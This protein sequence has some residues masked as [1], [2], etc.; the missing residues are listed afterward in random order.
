DE[1][2]Y[3]TLAGDL[4]KRSAEEDAAPFGELSLSSLLTETPEVFPAPLRVLRRVERRVRRLSAEGSA[5]AVDFRPARIAVL[6]YLDRERALS[7]EMENY[8]G[9][10]YEAPVLAA[11]LRKNPEDPLTSAQAERFILHSSDP[12]TLNAIPFEAAKDLGAGYAELLRAR[13]LYAEVEYAAAL[14]DYGVWLKAAADINAVCDFE[15]VSPVFAEIG[16]SARHIGEESAWAG[17]LFE[18]SAGLNGS[19][20]YA[21]AYQAGRL[22]R[23]LGDYDK[24]QSALLLAADAVKPGLD[25]DRAL[26]FGWRAM[27]EDA[28]TTTEEELIFL[29]RAVES[30]SNPDRFGDVM[31]EFLHRRIRR[32]EWTLLEQAWRDRGT[33]WPD[34]AR[35]LG[36]L[37]L[38]F[39]SSEGRLQNGADVA[40]L[41]K[42]AFESAPYSWSGLRA[43]GLLDTALPEAT[44]VDIGDE[45]DNPDGLPVNDAVLRLYLR[46]GLV[47]LAYEEV[48][49]S[50]YLYLEETVRMTA[51]SLQSPDPRKSI[52]IAGLLW[53]RDGFEPTQDDLLLRHPLPYGSLAAGKAESENLPV[54]ILYG[55]IRTESAWDSD[56]VSRSGAQGLAQFMPA[57]WEEWVGRLRYPDDAD[58]MDPETNLTLAASYLKWLDEREWT[59]G[60]VDVLVSYNAGGGRLRTWRNQQPGLGDDLFGM[61]V[62]IEEPRSYVGKVLSAATLYGYLYAGR[63]PRSLHEEWGLNMLEVNE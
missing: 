2:G 23:G 22:Y 4:R 35:S 45:H 62:P 32:G 60:W 21:A 63:S 29:S 18:A 27:Y 58:P 59:D 9:E 24:V 47:T 33:E 43:A 50:P 55:L 13:G 53:G 51:R 54:N 19:K 38:A 14:K 61:S 56:A 17:M 46:W 37:A 30:W 36:A 28:R 57:T 34:S 8:L 41:L 52:R 40:A 1:A 39:A 44:S 49:S 31:E 6:A 26:W 3:D 5:E 12:G 42:T 25:R 15:G 10:S 20:R 48:L 7:K 11:A 16:V